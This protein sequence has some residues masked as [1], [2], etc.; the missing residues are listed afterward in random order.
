MPRDPNDPDEKERVDPEGD[1][2]PPDSPFRKYIEEDFPG[3][4]DLEVIIIGA[5]EE[6]SYR[7]DST[8][9]A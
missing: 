4:E 1:G 9:E 3:D 2:L 6:G 7:T 8:E 5:P